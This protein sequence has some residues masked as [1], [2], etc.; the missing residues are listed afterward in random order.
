MATYEE[1]H[2]LHANSE[3]RN[4]VRVACFVAAE[5]IR[6]EDGATT[7]HASRLLWSKA[8]FEDPRS[9]SKRMYCAVLAA[10][11]DAS[12]AQIASASDAAIQTQVDA[13]V[14]HFATGV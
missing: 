13:A 1:L 8:V 9:E 7:N 14:D 11:K 4:R 12:V 3:L 5:A 6:T 2:E 10:N